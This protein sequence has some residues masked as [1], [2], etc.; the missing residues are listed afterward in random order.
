MSPTSEKQRNKD[1]VRH[2]WETRGEGAA[3]S[4]WE[5]RPRTP[6]TS[7]GDS[8][9]GS[10]A[11]DS[12]GLTAPRGHDPGRGRPPYSEPRRPG[13]QSPGPKAAAIASPGRRE[14]EPH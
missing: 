2:L 5:E 13:R 10:W 6:E 9:L 14:P 11:A 7:E 1:D 8:P 4:Q 3:S 12:A